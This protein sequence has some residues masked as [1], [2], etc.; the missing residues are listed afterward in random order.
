MKNPRPTVV[1]PFPSRDEAPFADDFLRFMRA[2]GADAARTLAVR[3]TEASDDGA[4]REDLHLMV[5]H[6]QAALPMRH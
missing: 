6:A 1:W 3:M 2:A 5:R 4:F